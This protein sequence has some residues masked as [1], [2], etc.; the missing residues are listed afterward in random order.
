MARCRVP[1]VGGGGY[2]IRGAPPSPLSSPISRARPIYII[3]YLSRI[4]IHIYSPFL[5]SESRSFLFGPDGCYNDALQ[6]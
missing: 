2:D 3:L 6:N 4:L 5:L 1:R